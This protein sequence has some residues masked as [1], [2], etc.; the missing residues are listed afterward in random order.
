MI[1]HSAE[2]RSANDYM[3]I[4][5]AYDKLEL[6]LERAIVENKYS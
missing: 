1:V 5:K 6:E 2:E 3:V 4:C